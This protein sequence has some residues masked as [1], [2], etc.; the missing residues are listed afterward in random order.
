MPVTSVP[1]IFL[2]RSIFLG[3]WFEHSELQESQTVDHV[4]VSSTAYQGEIHD[5]APRG[6]EGQPHRHQGK[7]S[8]K[9][10]RVQ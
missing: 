10:E 4:G 6:G 3:H 1:G 8:A 5:N 9:G 7:G 2:H